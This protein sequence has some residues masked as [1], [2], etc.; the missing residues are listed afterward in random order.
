[1]TIHYASEKQV[2]MNVKFNFGNKVVSIPF[3][4]LEHLKNASENDVKILLAL[5]GNVDPTAEYGFSESDINTAIAFWR[6]TGILSIGNTSNKTEK[7]NKLDTSHS[8]LPSAEKLPDYTAKEIK[9][10]CRNDET[11]NG[12]LDACQQTYKKIFS[13]ADCAI[14]IGLRDHLALDSEYILTLFAYCANKGKKSIRYAE[15]MAFSLID[16]GI[17]TPAALEAHIKK[18]EVSDS[19]EG[20]LRSMFG[21][22]DRALSKKEENCL[23]RWCGE[24]KYSLDVIQHAYEATVNAIGKASIPY[25]DA[26]LSKWHAAGCVTLEDVKKYDNGEKNNKTPSSYESSFDTDDFFESALRRS[27]SQMKENSEDK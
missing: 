26:I 4:V 11:L 15:K 21:I 7:E 8:A 10:L 18:L 13:N 23:L 24:W 1:M 2:T 22:K 5:A 25:T 16:E 14:V 27:Y 9:E 17:D 3:S 12:L 20:K 6:G 19:L